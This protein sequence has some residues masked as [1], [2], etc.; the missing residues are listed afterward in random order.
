MKQKTRQAVRAKT[1]TTCRANWSHIAVFAQNRGPET[2][3]TMTA[4]MTLEAAPNTSTRETKP[5]KFARVRTSLRADYDWNTILPILES[6][7]VAHVG[8]MDEDRPMVI[9]MA[10][11]VMDRTIYIHGAKAARI[12][13]KMSKDSQVCLTFTLIDGIVVARS[14]FHHSVNYRT[15]VIHGTARLVTDH[16]EAWDSLKAITEHLLPGRWDE[17]RPMTEKEQI[18]TGVIAIEI[19]HASAKIRQGAPVDDEEDYALPYWA[20]VVPVT[21]SLGQPIDDGKL[22]DGVKVPASPTN[23]ARKF[24]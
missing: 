22:L 17:V 4:E 12:V 8:F 10:F 16:Q 15:A 9:P 2:V 20:G 14:A 19:E 7:L 21:T 11:A 13:K 24:A 23:A 3:K 1:Q 18:S 5:P 6:S